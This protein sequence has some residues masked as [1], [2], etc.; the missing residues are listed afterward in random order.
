M[1]LATHRPWSASIVTP[2]QHLSAGFVVTWNEVSVEARITQAGMENLSTK[3]HQLA[4]HQ[5]ALSQSLLQSP[6]PGHSEN[7]HCR[8]AIF[9][10][11]HLTAHV[12]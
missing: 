1:G 11:F 8:P 5:E 6:Q 4:C 9:N 12:N 2:L 10:L 3:W 7:A